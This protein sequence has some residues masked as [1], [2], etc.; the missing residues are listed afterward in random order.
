MIQRKGDKSRETKQTHSSRLI[1]VDGKES[2]ERTSCQSGD[3]A[4]HTAQVELKASKLHLHL[5][6][7]LS[8]SF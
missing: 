3:G 7:L 1:C 2:G 8:V 4:G 6:L 5:F